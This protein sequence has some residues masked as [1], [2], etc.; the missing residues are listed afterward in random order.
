[1]KIDITEFSSLKLNAD[2]P[3]RDTVY[4]RPRS[5]GSPDSLVIKGRPS[6]TRLRRISMGLINPTGGTTTFRR[7]QLW[8][9][10]LRATEVAKDRGQAQRI[11][12]S[13]Q[14]SNLFSYNFLW[15]GRNADFL[16]VGETRG[17]G[18][19]PTT[20]P[21]DDLPPTAS[22]RH[23]HHPAGDGRFSRGLSQPRLEATTW[24]ATA[25]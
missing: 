10:E 8:F 9:D 16:S 5:Q 21:Q 15:D 7:G 3:L 24:C 12:F 23:R 14:A 17:L 19:P 22:S 2:F 18:A 1:V 13:G 4:T 20:S 11:N 6:F 25:C